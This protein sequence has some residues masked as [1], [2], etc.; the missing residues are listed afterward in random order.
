MLNRENQPGT[1]FISVEG[2]YRDTQNCPTEQIRRITVRALHG[3]HPHIPLSETILHVWGLRMSRKH[4]D[5]IHRSNWS[6]HM[7]RKR[8][9]EMGWGRREGQGHASSTS[10]PKTEFLC[11]SSAQDITEDT[12]SWF[13]EHSLRPFPCEILIVK[14]LPPEHTGLPTE[15]TEEGKWQKSGHRK[16]LPPLEMYRSTGLGFAGASVCGGI[17]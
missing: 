11:D 12:E 14:F 15:T 16:D 3:P 17:W 6:S 9:Q 8:K 10:S 7:E 1:V 13:P 2:S 4:P 5:P